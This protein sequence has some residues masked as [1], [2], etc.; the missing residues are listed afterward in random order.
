MRSG[1]NEEREGVRS[2]EEEE[3]E[4]GTGG[5]PRKART[6][7]VDVGNTFSKNENGK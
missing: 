4:G 2:E 3:E 5:V 1:R 6:P 7:R